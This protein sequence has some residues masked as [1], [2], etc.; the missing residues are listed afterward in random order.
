MCAQILAIGALIS[1]I[2]F[3]VQVTI[4]MSASSFLAVA[5]IVLREF[6][7][8]I[9]DLDI[10]EGNQ[11]LSP[12]LS[13]FVLFGF[14]LPVYVFVPIGLYFMEYPSDIMIY[15]VAFILLVAVCFERIFFQSILTYFLESEQ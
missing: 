13:G 9:Q 6:F 10:E 3:P 2:Y 11:V 7:W 5:T 14:A 12:N 4:A 1:F 8:R 15:T